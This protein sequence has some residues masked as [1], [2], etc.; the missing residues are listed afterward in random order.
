MTGKSADPTETAINWGS[1]EIAEHWNRN[2]ARRH[3]L[4]GPATERM[5]DM[6]NVQ[7]GSRVLDAAA[8][9]GEQTL[10]AARRV[11]PNGYVVA[12]DL[13][14]SMLNVAAEAARKAGLTN[15]ETR[16]M[17]AE[18]L[19]LSAGSF[20]AGI[21]RLGLML[22]PNPPKALR[23]IQ[24]ALKPRGKFAALV[25]STAAKN[26][27]Q[28]IPLMIVSR[29]G[30][31]VLPMFALGEP[32]TLENAFQEGGFTDVT[33]QAVP[34]RRRFESTSEVMRMLRDILFLREPMAKL[35]EGDRERAWTEIEQQLRRFETPNGLDLTGEFLIGAGTK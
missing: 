25:F 31:P 9:T 7:T 22:F 24:K 12:T 35:R 23:G 32:G 30:A 1:E 3:E 28:G 17:D 2:Q 4:I 5:L 20:D 16:V 21:C 8:G 33:V 18:N 6:A 34:V 14:Q 19:E 26:P 29:F 13:S 27:F 10:L 15:I 11:G